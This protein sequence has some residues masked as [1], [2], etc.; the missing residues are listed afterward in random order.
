MIAFDERY[1]VKKIRF[2]R[3]IEQNKTVKEEVKHACG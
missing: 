3:Y 2:I 1:A